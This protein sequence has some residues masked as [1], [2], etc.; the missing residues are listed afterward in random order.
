[1]QLEGHALANQQ[2]GDTLV[3]PESM[4]IPLLA[5][6]NGIVQQVSAVRAG[7]LVA[8]IVEDNAEG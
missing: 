3:V 2:E 1:M 7:Q 8:V 5:P 6:C 4:K